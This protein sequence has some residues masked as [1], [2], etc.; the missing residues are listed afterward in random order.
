MKGACQICART[1]VLRWWRAGVPRVAK[2]IAKRWGKYEN[3]YFHVSSFH[4]K[5]CGGAGGVDYVVMPF[6]AVLARR[7]DGLKTLRHGRVLG[8]VLPDLKHKLDYAHGLLRAWRRRA[9]PNHTV[10][11]PWTACLAKAAWLAPQPAWRA[12]CA[13]APHT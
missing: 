3:A 11:E 4:F 13:F 6:I 8:K 7:R 5:N 2:K 12:Q 9:P 1:V 10:P